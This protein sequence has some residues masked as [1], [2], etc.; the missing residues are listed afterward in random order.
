[1]L[2][3]IKVI[4]TSIDNDR[5]FHFNMFIASR[6]SSKQKNTRERA[7]IKYAS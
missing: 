4:R 7:G 6:D 3:A 5:N 2:D 1:M